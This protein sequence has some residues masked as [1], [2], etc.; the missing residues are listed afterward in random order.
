MKVTSAKGELHHALQYRGKIAI[1]LP[2][3]IDM[4]R[5]MGCSYDPATTL[6]VIKM[7][8]GTEDMF[9]PAIG[10]IH[11]LFQADGINPRVREMV[12]LRAAKVLNS[13]Y[14]WQANSVLAK[15]VGLTAEEIE[16]A[17][18]EG[19]VSGINPEYVLACKATDELSA[20]ATLQMERWKNC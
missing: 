16:A 17:A 13:P 9:Q 7:F 19:P 5:V 10:F 12:I 4:I 14:E 8:A 1:E 2:S 20:S 11:A 18:R 6:N 3:D 15:N